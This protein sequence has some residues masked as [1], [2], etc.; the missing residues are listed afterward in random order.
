MTLKSFSG[1][2]QFMHPGKEHRVDKAG[3]TAWNAKNHLRKFLVSA[4]RFV[5]DSGVARSGNLSFWGE[6]EA[7]SQV[8]R[9]WAQAPGLPTHAVQPRYP[10]APRLRPG[11]QNTDPYVFGERFRYTLCQQIWT[12]GPTG[13]TDLQP[14]SMVL[15]GSHQAGKFLLDTVFVVGDAV[16]HS[17]NTWETRLNGRVSDVYRSV[18]LTPMYADPEIRDD[19][20]FCLYSGA[21]LESP[22]DGM[23]SFF[24]CRPCGDGVIPRF[25]R[26]ALRSDWFLNPAKLQGRTMSDAS[27]IEVSEAWRS[28][29]SQ[30]QE[31]GLSLGVQAVEP[32]RTMVPDSYW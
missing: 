21:S 20:E 30:V 10:G 16:R 1:V 25:E 24:P 19:S 15:F 13:M 2:V 27:S 31:A 23:F 11:L 26:P 12:H 7:P 17:R 9:S 5:D 6:W 18:T 4:G 8:V 3:W 28:I 32:T 14:G 22:V 29:V